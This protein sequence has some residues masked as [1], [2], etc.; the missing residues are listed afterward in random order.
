MF[1]AVF[2]FVWKHASLQSPLYRLNF[3]HTAGLLCGAGLFGGDVP[4]A[5]S[6]KW[7]D[8]AVVGYMVNTNF[9]HDCPV[10]GLVIPTTVPDPSA[11]GPCAAVFVDGPLPCLPLTA[12]LVWSVPVVWLGHYMACAGLSVSVPSL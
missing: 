11:C 5:A 6:C 12:S 2:T 8:R 1:P 10:H 3:L 7:L 9:S 4:F